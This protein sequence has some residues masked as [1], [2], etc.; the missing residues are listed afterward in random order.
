MTRRRGPQ[1]S[2]PEGRRPQDGPP[3]ESPEF[4]FSNAVELLRQV[5]LRTDALTHAAEDL[6]EKIPWSGDKVVRRQR[7]RLGHLLGDAAEASEQMVD[8]CSLI[9]E[10]FIKRSQGA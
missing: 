5:A 8:A 3:Q 10:E 1:R 9:S 6:D 2:L 7:E 4:R